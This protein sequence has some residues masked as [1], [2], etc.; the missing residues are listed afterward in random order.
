MSL[1]IRLSGERNQSKDIPVLKIFTQ[2]D[3]ITKKLFFSA[4][5]KT[6]IPDLKNWADGTSLVFAMNT[7]LVYRWV[8]D[9]K[10]VGAAT[11]SQVTLSHMYNIRY[12]YI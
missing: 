10:W 8:E 3:F 7:L 12:L 4:E 1:R 9:L 5:F 11:V 6:L 2:T